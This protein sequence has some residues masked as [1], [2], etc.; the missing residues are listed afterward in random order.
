M[1]DGAST[2]TLLGVTLKSNLAHG[3]V[4][5]EANPVRRN[6]RET[7]KRQDTLDIGTPKGSWGTGALD[8]ESLRRVAVAFRGCRK[9]AGE[10]NAAIEVNVAVLVGRW[11]TRPCEFS[12]PRRRRQTKPG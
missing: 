12:R 3:A 9:A 7:T 5:A 10:V 4:P 2:S 6:S 8:S 11:P 1:V